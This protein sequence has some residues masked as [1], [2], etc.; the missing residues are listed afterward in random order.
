MKVRE[1]I[2]SKMNRTRIVPVEV[3][4]PYPPTAPIRLH[5]FI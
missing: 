2:T 3:Q 5:S 4:P 1:T